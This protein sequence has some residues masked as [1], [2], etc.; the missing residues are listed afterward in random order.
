MIGSNKMPHDRL[1][2][3][4][5]CNHRFVLG[6]SL[7]VQLLIHFGREAGHKRLEDDAQQVQHIESCVDDLAAPCGVLFGEL[8]WLLV[9]KIRV[10][11]RG[12]L[13][14]YL[15]SILQL[16]SFHQQSVSIEFVKKLLY[17]R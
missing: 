1:V 6:L 13:H 15:E 17:K 11:I 7:D 9:L 5:L 14:R 3:N 16:D 10:A 12:E 8:P 4:K 2:F